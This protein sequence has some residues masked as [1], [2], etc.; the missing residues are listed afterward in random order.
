MHPTYCL[1]FLR[2]AFLLG[3]LS[4]ASMLGLGDRV[5]CKVVSSN[6]DVKLHPEEAQ[7][8]CGPW[9]HTLLLQTINDEK[10]WMTSLTPSWLLVQRDFGAQL[11]TI[12]SILNPLRLS[13]AL[14]EGILD[15]TC[16][17]RIIHKYTIERHERLNDAQP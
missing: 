5:V 8:N 4:R 7:A 14:V 10:K 15:S 17:H 12:I 11:F 2:A 13:L 3:Y 9:P 1:A 16:I 6:H